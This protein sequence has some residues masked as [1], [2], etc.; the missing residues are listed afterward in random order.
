MALLDYAEVNPDGFGLMVH[1]SPEVI[2]GSHFSTI[3][4][5]T[6]ATTSR[7]YW[8]P[9]STISGFDAATAPLYAQMLAGTVGTMEAVWANDRTPAKEV[10][11]AHLVNLMWNGFA[12]FGA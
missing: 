11:A 5:P 9:Y 8:P 7:N 4:C 2:S 6:W 1:Q 3:S 10:L 12:R